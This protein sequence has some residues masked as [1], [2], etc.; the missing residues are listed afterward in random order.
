MTTVE[1]Y[2]KEKVEEL[3]AYYIGDLKVEKG[4]YF[5][6]AQLKDEIPHIDFENSIFTVSLIYG[7]LGFGR[8][9]FKLKADYSYIQFCV[10]RIELSKKQNI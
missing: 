6:N 9:F 4:D 2:L 10:N 7:Y 3:G 5:F 1:E 8:T